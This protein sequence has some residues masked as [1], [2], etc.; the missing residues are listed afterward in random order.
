MLTSQMRQMVQSW[1]RRA[2]AR[3][4]PNGEYWKLP[5]GDQAVVDGLV[6]LVLSRGG[7][8]SLVHNGDKREFYAYASGGRRISWGI[9]SPEGENVARGVFESEEDRIYDSATG[10]W[11]DVREDVA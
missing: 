9:N 1:Y 2:C 5:L 6:E 8:Q 4:S 7:R 10:T 11:R 3:V